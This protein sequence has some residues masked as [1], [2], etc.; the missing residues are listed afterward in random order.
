M[1]WRYFVLQRPVGSHQC[2]WT[3][4][5]G[6]CI[7]RPSSCSAAGR[8]ALSQLT[9][10]HAVVSRLSCNTAYSFILSRQTRLLLLIRVH[11]HCSE[12]S[13]DEWRYIVR[14]TACLA[15]I[16]RHCLPSP[17]LSNLLAQEVLRLLHKP[18][19]SSICHIHGGSLRSLA[20][21]P[22]VT[23]LDVLNAMLIAPSF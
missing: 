10:S 1:S 22:A 15:V 3:L 18:C 20:P 19:F 4:A 6:F 21:G 17:A 14:Q 12:Q 9:T 2:K 23:T 13:A 5:F 7:V 11:V 8:A 16:S